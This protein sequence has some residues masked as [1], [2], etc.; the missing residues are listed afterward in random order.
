[1]TVA[2]G[3]IISGLVVIVGLIAGIGVLAAVA[4]RQDGSAV[5]NPSQMMR[6][7]RSGQ[8]HGMLQEH[9]DMLDRMRADAS[10]QMLRMMENDRMTQ[11]M[12][13]GD[14]IRMQEEHQAEI[15]RM[16][17]RMPGS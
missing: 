4:G 3:V 2:K 6:M 10:P 14:M 9:Q 15:D 1:M 5:A 7:E 13:S 12:R 8:M 17:G 11:M 16:M